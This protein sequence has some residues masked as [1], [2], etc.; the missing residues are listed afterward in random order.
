MKKI[1]AIILVCCLL[2]S[3]CGQ[4]PQQPTPGLESAKPSEADITLETVNPSPEVVRSLLAEFKQAEP[5][6]PDL[7]DSNLLTYLESNIYSEIIS[8]LDSSDYFVENVRAVYVSKEFLEELSYNSKSNIFFGYT[9]AEL[10]EQFQGS[11]YVFTLG[12]NN[13]TIVEPF[14]GLPDPYEQVLKNVVVGTGVI[15]VCVTISSV[16]AATG[17]P[18]ISMIFAMSAKT[19]TTAALSSAAFGGISAGILTG[20]Q[21]G[22]MDAAIEAATINASEG[23]KWGAIS[24][25]ILGGASEAVALKGATLHGL[26]MDEAAIIQ[27]ESQYPLDVI[28][29]FSNIDQYYICQE[30]GLE[31][32]LVDGQWPMLIRDIDLNYIDDLGRTNLER[33]QQGLA[34]L[35]PATGN[36][37]QLHHIGQRADST[38]AILTE[39]EHMQGGN[40]T[41]WHDLGKATEVHGEGN[42]WDATRQ[43][44]WKALAGSVSQG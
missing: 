25:T 28:K 22:N 6:Y 15:L 35:D 30:A 13:E 32:T 8:S 40:N 18:A 29:E 3:S 43:A 11:K 24:G 33:M 9:L 44:I 7:N 39:A 1:V 27:K 26:T 5:V 31:S 37:Y 34:A 36:S 2:L 16:A 42:N 41:I 17:A 21:T 19:G 12:D 4:N 23:F 38:L 10:D 14:E 20:I